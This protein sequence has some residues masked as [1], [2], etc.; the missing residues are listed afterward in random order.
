MM[1]LAV[2][3]LLCLLLLLG[4]V[5]L[6][7]LVFEVEYARQAYD[8]LLEYWP[9]QDGF[10][11]HRTQGVIVGAVL[12]LFGLYGFAPKLPSRK[13]GASISQKGLHGEI[14]FELKPIRRKLLKIMRSMPE[15]YAIEIDVKPD[16]DKRSAR[17]NAYVVLKNSAG[18][19]ANRCAKLVRECLRTAATDILGLTELSAVCVNI[20]DV[21]VD[22]GATSKQIR[23]QMLL[24][25]EE[26]EERA[27]AYAVAHPPMAAVTLDETAPGAQGGL[28]GGAPANSADQ[29]TSA[30]EPVEQAAEV[31]VEELPEATAMGETV[32]AGDAFAPPPLLD[33][34]EELPPAP[35]IDEQGDYAEDESPVS[36]KTIVDGARASAAQGVD[37]ADDGAFSVMDTPAAA[38]ETEAEEG[39]PE[40]GQEEDQR[41]T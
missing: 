19:G 35:Q 38:E 32:D 41:W 37:P 34:E 36:F 16:M 2:M 8:R 24:R 1:K 11:A 5:F 21:H 22:V 7:G 4:G 27:A 20:R 40:S 30:Q 9:I 17:I 10:A 14:V 12:V 28:V 18:V 29:T 31:P 33:E 26:E 6:L 25:A 23:E 15:V 13:R 3:K 39:A